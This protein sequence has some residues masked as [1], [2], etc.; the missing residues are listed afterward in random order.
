M[1]YRLSDEEQL[2]QKTVRDFAARDLA[3]LVDTAERSGTFPR[4]KIL[5]RMAELGLLSIGVPPELGGA[6]GTS[7]MLCLVAEEV[8]RVCGGFAISVMGSVLSPAAVVRARGGKSAPGVLQALM[9]GTILPAMAFTE[10]GAGSDLAAIRTTVARTERGLVLNGSKTISNGRRRT[11]TSSPR[12]APT[13][14]TGRARNAPRA[15]ASIPCR[16]GS[17]ASP[18]GARSPSSACARARRASST[19]RTSCSR[20][21]RL[22]RAAGAAASAA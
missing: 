7:L 6:G 13:T 21:R 11:S 10:P 15:S 19:S 1:S 5:P 16:A 2:L 18:S 22:R 17:R 12:C 4:E 14:P 3:P 20:R 8:A 9:Q